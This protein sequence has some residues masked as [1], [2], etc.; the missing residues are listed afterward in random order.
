MHSLLRLSCDAGIQVSFHGKHIQVEV[1][2][3]HLCQAP[4]CDPKTPALHHMEER[5]KCR[6]KTRKSRHDYGYM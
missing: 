6:V 2:H 5:V 3:F 1:A 4:H